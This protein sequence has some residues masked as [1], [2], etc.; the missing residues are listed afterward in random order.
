MTIPL[1]NLEA[2]LLL[3]SSRVAAN[4]D[5]GEQPALLLLLPIIAEWMG[6]KEGKI[7]D[8]PK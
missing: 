1:S 4:V 2:F 3:S 5:E 6:E 8:A 7:I